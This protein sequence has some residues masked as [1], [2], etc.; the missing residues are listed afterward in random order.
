MQEEQSKKTVT[1]ITRK[2]STLQPAKTKPE[3]MK[4]KTT[5]LTAKTLKPAR[6]NPS[7]SRPLNC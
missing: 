6:E 2:V 5:D 1:Q 3:T 7:R 4:T